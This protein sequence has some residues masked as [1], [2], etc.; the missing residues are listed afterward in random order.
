MTDSADGPY[1]LVS[2]T[3]PE[4]P[5]LEGELNKT[6]QNIQAGATVAE[7][8]ERLQNFYEEHKGDIKF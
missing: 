4:A 6:F 7:E 2:L 5:G 8:L 1:E 3:F